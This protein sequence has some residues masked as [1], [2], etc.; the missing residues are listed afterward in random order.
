MA[1]YQCSGIESDQ[2]PKDERQK[3]PQHL[4]LCRNKGIRNS[5]PV[6][7]ASQRP[8]TKRACSNTWH[9]LHG[10]W[11]IFTKEERSRWSSS[12][13]N[14]RSHFWCLYH[15]RSVL[16]QLRVHTIHW[17]IKCNRIYR[18]KDL[19]GTRRP[20]KKLYRCMERRGSIYE[21]DNIYIVWEQTIEIAWYISQTPVYIKSDIH[22]H[23]V[24]IRAYGYSYWY[25]GYDE[26]GH[27]SVSITR[28]A[29]FPRI[30]GESK[31][32]SNRKI[33]LSNP[34]TILEVKG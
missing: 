32:Y 8:S 12:I 16:G 14:P 24:E 33:G 21:G 4:Q 27:L 9:I 23:T 6:S 20:W 11:V 29:L 15:A 3:E 28:P 5:E 34:E 19:L 13:A 18:Y 31:I 26:F 10:L 25:L 1:R 30:F 7:R 22:I 17:S 2:Y